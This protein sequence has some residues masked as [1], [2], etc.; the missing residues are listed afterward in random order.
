[1]NFIS[2][3]SLIFLLFTCF[4][5]L[6]GQSDFRPG[7]IITNNSDTVNGLIDYRGAERNAKVCV[8]KTDKSSDAKQY[9]P[10]D[11][12]GYGF[13]GH[14]FYVSK[15]IKLN[16]DGMP[17]FAEFLVNGATSL[18]YY[19]RDSR[20]YYLI[21]KK[22]GQQVELTNTQDTLNVSGGQYIR[23]SKKNI[24]LLRFAFSDCQKLYPMIDKATLEGKFLISLVKK[25]NECTGGDE[26]TIVYKKQPPF[27]RFKIAPFV[28]IARPYLKFNDSYRYQTVASKPII[29]PSIGFLCNALLPR[30]SEKFSLQL[31]GEYGKNS[32]YGKGI[33]PVTS[34][35]EEV[36]VDISGVK[37]NWD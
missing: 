26:E 21:E 11:I 9:Q 15:Q 16:G 19:A 28:S 25:Y 31:S 24:G 22:N 2:K 29:S 10:F 13:P 7:Y 6:K 8:F 20:I 17:F 1:M 14:R 23:E 18:Y 4:L 33:S 27:L 30:V 32:F 5:D 34:A 35:Q 12:K 3:L 37:E 36:F